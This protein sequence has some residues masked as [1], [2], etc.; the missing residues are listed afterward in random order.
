MPQPSITVSVVFLAFRFREIIHLVEYQDE[1]L[2]NHNMPWFQSEIIQIVGLYEL[3]RKNCCN[4]SPLAHISSSKRVNIQSR[5]FFKL[6]KFSAD[7]IYA[8]L[9]GHAEGAKT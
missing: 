1:N 3:E 4:N 6:Y 8:L 5:A 2:K 7:G 9:K